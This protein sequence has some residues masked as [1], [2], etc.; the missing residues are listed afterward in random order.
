MIESMINLIIQ[1]EKK[2]K[3]ASVIY[4]NFLH[5]NKKQKKKKLQ[6]TS[7]HDTAFSLFEFPL[8]IYQT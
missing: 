5:I 2:K 3:N 6:I 4:K 8:Q 7:F 1:K